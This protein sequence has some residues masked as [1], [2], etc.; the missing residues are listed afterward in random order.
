[1]YWEANFMAMILSLSLAL[2]GTEKRNEYEGNAVLENAGEETN[3]NC[4][5][6]IAT[7][8][9]SLDIVGM[10]RCDVPIVSRDF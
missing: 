3:T 4:S 7:R 6:R 5:L 9:R 8:M 2:L 1:M 10:I